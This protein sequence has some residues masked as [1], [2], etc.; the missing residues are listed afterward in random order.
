M[1]VIRLTS[2]GCSL[3]KLVKFNIKAPFF[4][5]HCHYQQ[6]FSC[7]SVTLL[8]SCLKGTALASTLNTLSACLTV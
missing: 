3:S 8:Y 5:R 6:V 1:S 7:R 2:G 4:E